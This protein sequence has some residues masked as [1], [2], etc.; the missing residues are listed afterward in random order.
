M[1]WGGWDVSSIDRPR[2]T[3]PHYTLQHG[4]EEELWKVQRGKTCKETMETFIKVVTKTEPRWF[5]STFKLGNM[6]DMRSSSGMGRR[7]SSFGMV[8]QMQ[9]TFQKKRADS[10]VG[11]MK[12]QSHGGSMKYDRTNCSGKKD[13]EDKEGGSG[14]GSG[15]PPSPSNQGATVKVGDTAKR[16]SLLDDDETVR[17]YDDDKDSLAETRSHGGESSAESVGRSHIGSSGR[18]ENILSQDAASEKF[19]ALATERGIFQWM[20][21]FVINSDWKCTDVMLIPDGDGNGYKTCVGLAQDPGRLRRNPSSDSHKEIKKDPYFSPILPLTK[22]DCVCD[23]SRFK[24]VEEQ[25]IHMI[26]AMKRMAF[27][28]SGWTK[29][30]SSDDFGWWRSKMEKL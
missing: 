19:R 22:E 24:S 3:P 29:S 5:R 17:P 25:D 2:L 21:F 1:S 9:G 12:Y 7:K 30:E 11:L 8:A 26:K 20:V 27:S 4:S 16:G 18:S 13:N 6:L 14:S 23:L 10:H 28:T 15:S